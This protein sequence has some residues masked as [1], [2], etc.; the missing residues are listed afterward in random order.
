MYKPLTRIL[1]IMAAL[2]VACGRDPIAP[3]GQD[4]SKLDARRS[5]AYV[6]DA[7]YIDGFESPAIGPF[8]SLTQ[9]FGTVGLTSTVAHTGG[10]AVQFTSAS[11]GQRDLH[12]A[13]RFSGPQKGAFTIWFN[14]VAAGSQTLYE[15]LN[16]TNSLAPNQSA[17]IG[18]MDYDAHCYVAWLTDAGNGVHGP[19]RRCGVFPQVT[20][21]NVPRTPGWHRLSIVVGATETTFSI[22]GVNVLVVPG[23]FA[24]DRVDVSVTGPSWRPNTVA[25]FDDFEFDPNAGYV[26]VSRV[27]ITPSLPQRVT[28]GTST[29]L[30]A[31]T[32]DAAGNVLLGRVV[33]WS[34]SNPSAATVTAA[35]RVTGVAGGRA[36]I[37]ATSEGVS[38]SVD[39]WVAP[40][41]IVLPPPAPPITPP[42]PVGPPTPNPPLRVCMPTVVLGY[43]VTDR[44]YDLACG[45]NPLAT[46][47]QNLLIHYAS[48]PIGAL[49]EICVG[50]PIPT[51][52]SIVS[53]HVMVARCGNLLPF[54]PSIHRIR[55]IT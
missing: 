31:T 55:R 9:T 17:N 37:T 13:H 45:Y 54:S 52:W 50:E 12:M 34:S 46:P 22:D 11:G 25:Y 15:Q 38:T 41:I 28:V 29:N 20:T 4:G 32:Y 40:P 47:N 43:V 5:M 14:D 42:P 2:T 7:P 16:L 49:I 8:W 33:T 19:N 26:P 53:S 18:I 10:Q 30:T 24:F 48:L 3:P 21:T 51:G 35:G 39:V 23:D 27:V 44:R 1:P 6:A 36:T